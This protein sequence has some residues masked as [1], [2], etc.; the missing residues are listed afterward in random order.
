MKANKKILGASAALALSLAMAAGS[1]FAWFTTGNS[2]STDQFEL[3]VTSGTAALLISAGSDANWKTNYSSN[4]T[5]DQILNGNGYFK[6]GG[7]LYHAENITNQTDSAFEKVDALK[8]GTNIA[9]SYYSKSDDTFTVYG[10]NAVVTSGNKD[11]IYK[12]KTDGLYTATVDSEKKPTT[13]TALGAND[14]FAARGEKEYYW[15]KVKLDALTTTDGKAFKYENNTAAKYGTYVTLT[16]NF[17]IS[18]EGGYDVYLLDDGDTYKSSITPNNTNARSVTYNGPA[19]EDTV[20]GKALTKNTA[21][22][23]RAAYASRVSFIKNGTGDVTYWAPYDMKYGESQDGNT[24][25]YENNANSFY[26]KNFAADYKQAFESVNGWTG[27]TNS[28]D[29]PTYSDSA[30][31]VF[32]SSTSDATAATVISELNAATGEGSVTINIWIEGKD[33]DCFNAILE[34]SL[35][36]QMAFTAVKKAQAPQQ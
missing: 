13:M 33:G 17:R 34:D 3:G 20:Y 7:E 14:T 24:A 30:K 18:D 36:I 21:T 8:D 1:T 6:V 2:V 31:T 27:L 4:L 32:K 26:I 35:N 23:T 12:F 29:N 9:G 11:N 28:T 22:T 19:Q 15:S 25:G 16:Y 5:S 10:D